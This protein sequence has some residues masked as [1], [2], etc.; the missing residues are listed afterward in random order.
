ME[1]RQK[2]T[3]IISLAGIL[4]LLFLSNFLEP[5]TITPISNI[6]KENLNQILMVEGKITGLMEYNNKTFQVLTISDST[7]S[8]TATAG[9][10]SS[11]AERINASL[12]YRATGKI[13]IY[14]STLQISINRL[15]LA[16]I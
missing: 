15:E 12:T 5:R 1:N 11:I 14:N 2:L 4:V 10:K 6:T 9:S 7:G 16:P 8:I 3:L 13:Q